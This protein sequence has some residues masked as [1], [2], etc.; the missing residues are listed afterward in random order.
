MFST[1]TGMF[2]LVGSLFDPT[3]ANLVSKGIDIIDKSSF[4][5]EEKADFKLN[6]MNAHVDHIK[7]VSSDMNQTRSLTRK[8]ISMAIIIPSLPANIFLSW[9]G[10]YAIW[11]NTGQLSEI[12]DLLFIINS[13]TFMV[14]GFYFGTS[15]RPKK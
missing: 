1:I 13:G 10:I 11:Y 8:W 5:D 6:I 12:R 9:M 15:S 14:L 3:N 2:K 4:K 7:A